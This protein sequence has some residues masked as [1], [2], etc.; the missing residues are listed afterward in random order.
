MRKLVR[1]IT[2]VSLL[3]VFT[4]TCTANTPVVVDIEN[5]DKKAI[6]EF[7]VNDMVKQGFN[8]M[9]TNEYQVSF[10]RDVTNFWAQ[11]LYGS[12]FNS[13]PELRTY[14]NLSQSGVNTRITADIKV[15]T[16]PNSGFE[17]YTV[18]T[19]N[20]WQ[21]YLDGIKK[22]FNG[23]SSY[24]FTCS[25]KK[26]DDCFKITEIVPGGPAD[27]AEL[28]VGDM[29]SKLNGATVEDLNKKK[30]DKIFIAGNVGQE[31]RVTTKGP[32]KET[33]HV[34]TKALIPPAYKK[35]A[36]VSLSKSNTP[37]FGFTNGQVDTSSLMPIIA[38]TLGSSADKEGLKAGDKIMSIN[39]IPVSEYNAKSFSEAFSG[40]EDAKV[41]LVIAPNDE[42]AERTVILT[43]S[44]VITKTEL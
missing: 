19:N 35:P 13:T 6:A 36:E 40:G 44:F 9:N 22:Y 17:N 24:G 34:L 39:G 18:V 3:F 7:I 2:L 12:Q 4:N 16:N 11:V 30:I 43:K 14:F 21:E 41:T 31:L 33:V 28:K 10:R 8:I 29:I 32:L 37:V 27:K 15:V 5:V 26:Q 42:N 20:K 38:V 25:E 23:Y 1:L